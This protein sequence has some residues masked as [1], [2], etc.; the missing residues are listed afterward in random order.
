MK[1][2]EKMYV[3]KAAMICYCMMNIVLA[4]AYCLEFVKNL[5]GIGY[6]VLML[7]LTL[8]PALGT[9]V[10]YLVNKGNN[11]S[12]YI[13]GVCFIVM[14]T[15][16]ILTTNS[17]LTYTYIFPMLVVVALFS[18]VWY[19][20]ILGVLTVVVN[21]VDIIVRAG[22]G[23]Y[24]TPEAVTDLE[25][26]IAGIV[27]VT[28]F[29]ILTTVCLNKIN[30]IRLARV[31]A[32]KD[33]ADKNLADTLELSA[34]ISDGISATTEKMGSLGESVAHIQESMKEISEG[35]NETAEAVQMQLQRTED[36]QNHIAQVRNTADDINSEMQE[37]LA[38]IAGGKE[39]VD[40]LT[41]QVEK[42]TDANAVVLEKMND[43]AVNADKMNNIIVAINEIANKTGLLALNASIEAARAGEA[44]RGFSVVAGEISSLASQ[45][46]T[47]T[48]DITELIVAIT[49][50]LSA[51]SEAIDLVTDCNKS[52]AVSAKEVSESF[53]QIAECTELIGRQTSEMNATIESLRVANEDI[54]EGI[55]TISAITEEVSAH[56]SE[57]YD[58]CEEN[59]VMVED[60][61]K[62]VGK[63]NEATKEYTKEQD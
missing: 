2:S 44:G 51:V 47:A 31:N 33:K 61:A 59:S 38:I 63:L 53:G 13:M 30:T 8:I 50:E 15:F 42:S 1:N 45:T 16:A 56:S 46:K 29:L 22:K 43:L 35:S 4:G 57:T 37:A 18:D 41:K 21:T 34:R 3:N 19:S 60:V 40:T 11:I 5:R 52:H 9:I 25:I 36:I 24:S 23:T 55:Q 14:Y 7:G 17:S 39:H 20:V 48:V 6:I 27:F 49:E 54:V 58:A 12:K 62:I 32:E 10:L 28:V 26:R